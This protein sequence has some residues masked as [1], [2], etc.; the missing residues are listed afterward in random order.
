MQFNY[1]SH[2]NKLQNPTH[3][4]N[5]FNY[6]YIGKFTQLSK[7]LYSSDIFG[8]PLDSLVLADGTTLYGKI[9]ED[10]GDVNT[11]LEFV[12]GTLNPLATNYT[13]QVYDEDTV[14]TSSGDLLGNLGLING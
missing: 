12:P 14:I 3:K 8:A 1:S 9:E 7:P 2:Y 13:Q 11:G 10:F 5:F 4:D 6:G